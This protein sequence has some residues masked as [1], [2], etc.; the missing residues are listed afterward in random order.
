V[1]TMLSPLPWKLL[2]DV[3]IWTQNWSWIPKPP[4]GAVSFKYTNCTLC[5]SG[6]AA[7]VRCIEA[8]PVS[9][10]G[11]RSDIGLGFLC[12]LGLVAHHLRYHPDRVTQPLVRAKGDELKPSSLDDATRVVSGKLQRLAQQTQ[13]S[14]SYLAILGNRPGTAGSDALLALLARFPH[15]AYVGCPNDGD[16]VSVLGSMVEGD[17]NW[18]LDIANS[19]MVL[20]FGAPLLEG[21]G[22]S[23][24]MLAQFASSDRKTRLIHVEPNCSLTARAADVWL[25]IQPGSEAALAL[26]LAN[27]LIEA[28]LVDP[29]ATCPDLEVDSPYRKL[30]AEF[31][32]ERVAGLTGLKPEVIT[33]TARAIAQEG[34]ALVISRGYVSG[35]V[36]R[37]EELAIQGLN[38]LLGNLDRPGGAL[39]RPS[40][41]Q[42]QVAGPTPA[43]QPGPGVVRALAAIPDG[44]VELLI[45]DAS[46][47]NDLPP[48][49]AVQPKLSPD[50]AVVV[51]LA[52]LPTAWAQ[53][54]DVV[55]PSPVFG[56]AI[57]ELP[58]NVDDTA[59]SLR[60][61]ARLVDP[62]PG[63]FNLLDFVNHT[64]VAAGLA[65]SPVSY[66]DAAKQKVAAIHQAG[67]GNVVSPA[68]GQAKAVTDYSSSDELWTALAGGARWE[69]AAPEAIKPATRRFS[70]A[71]PDSGD[72]E[73]M[74]KAAAQRGGL[75]DVAPS[76]YPLTVVSAEGRAYDSKV[77]PLL[78]K[79]TWES[80]LHAER[81]CMIN[82]ATAA[83]Q[84]VLAG[85]T[86]TVQ[87]PSGSLDVPVTL[88]EEIMPGVLLLEDP[89]GEDQSGLM[90]GTDATCRVMPGRLEVA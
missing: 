55:V 39:A 16:G 41:S 35:P 72:V 42:S 74:R 32:A 23:G 89:T 2:D 4:K 49:A 28:K 80:G 51:V 29:S 62:R 47:G 22:T 40:P 13:P 66:E 85:T 46:S 10:A 71:G 45:V 77:S 12:P 26:G 6:C 30:V 52:G 78:A 21:W 59:N 43:S 34:P 14:D 88:S 48:W 33:Q 69:N 11:I 60:L 25:S 7:Q 63:L 84:G 58:G 86:V 70:L 87:T 61:S 83:K 37:A 68:D 50:Q 1:G 65:T 18:A 19:K 67:I 82:P 64:A 3:S 24:R 44:S 79:I 5:G 54:A 57:E 20:S 76:E 38:F 53:R 27:V 36:S 75:A 15:A 90:T 81:T 9:L 8:E 73:R 56:E 31:S 17:Q